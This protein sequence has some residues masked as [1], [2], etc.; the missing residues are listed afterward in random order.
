MK[1]KRVMI[2]APK[3]GSGKT[4]VTCALLQVLKAYG[5]KVASY[6]CG[7]DYI[8]PMFHEK[9]IDVPA[10]NL[11]TFFTDEEKTRELFQN[12][13]KKMDFAV[14]EGVMGLYDGLGGVR[15]EGSSYHLAEVTKTPIVLVVDAKGMGRSMI[16]L[17]AGFLNYDKKHLIQGIILNRIS[18]G[19]YETLKPWIE[20]ELKIQVIGFL[21]EE[22]EL[23]I[24]SRHLGLF[25][26]DEVNSIKEKLQ[27]VSEL[28]SRTVSIEY[29]KE[30]AESAEE[31]EPDE[32]LMEKMLI[33]KYGTLIYKK[34]AGGL[35]REVNVWD[36]RPTIAV[37]KDEAFCFYYADN[38]H[39]LK[40]YGAKITYF[41]PLHDKKLPE[42]CHALLIGGG[43]PELYARQLSAN[44]KMREAVKDAVKNEMPIVAECGGFMYLHSFLKDKEG[45]CYD[46]AGVISA[47]CFYTGKLVRFGYIELREKQK[48]FLL[49]GKGIKGHEFHYYDSTC[50]GTD[51]IAVKPVTGKEYSCIIKNKT[52]WMGF[53][54]LYYPSN[55]VFARAFI[56]K[57]K[58]YQKT[59]I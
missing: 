55:P 2:A 30:I 4:V 40:E 20:E 52:Q 46:M 59:T 29:I 21:P 41:S 23:H 50:N 42:G 22:K 1:I 58:K 37:A 25:L 9:I 54:H 36:S 44:T 39:L 15:E 10:K 31:L 11:D 47:T 49:N 16:P 57:A 3:S 26:P 7:P 24:E 51:V 38:I 19:Y 5:W 45:L 14:F 43:Y 33:D 28:F 27:A 48:H 32:T 17:I 34:A 18:K 6:K 56:E 8:D 12:S 13:A 53:P 35:T